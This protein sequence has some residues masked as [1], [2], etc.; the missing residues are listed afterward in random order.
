MNG[1]LIQFGK[2]FVHAPAVVRSQRTNLDL[3]TAAQGLTRGEVT[4]INHAAGVG[5]FGE[6][7]FDPFQRFP[8]VEDVHVLAGEMLEG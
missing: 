1:F 2:S 7:I 5:L 8:L 6:Q 3:A 4:G